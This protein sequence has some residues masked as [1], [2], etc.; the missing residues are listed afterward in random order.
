[1]MIPISFIA[2]VLFLLSHLQRCPALSNGLARTPPL[3]FNG[4][5][6][7]SCEGTET[8]YKAAAQ[9]LISLGL[10]E[11]GYNRLNIDCGWQAI[12]RTSDGTFAWNS[13]RYP[14]GIPFLSN[15]VHGLGLE[16]GL[17]SDAGFFACDD[18]GGTA[19]F[20][21]S[22]GFEESDAK[23]FASWGADYLKYDNCYAVSPT[24]FVNPNP[25]IDLKPHYTAMANALATVQRPI[26]FSI[27]EWG[28][29]DPAR[30]APSIGNSYRIANDIGPPASFDNLFRIINQVVPIT[31][32]AGPGAW[33]DLDLLEVGNPGLTVDE[34]KTHF[35]FWAAA[36]S[37]LLVST[38]LTNPSNTTL[39]ILKNMN[40]LAI[41]QDSLG[42][43][44]GFKRRYANDHDVWAGPLSDGSTV[45]I[46]INMQT[47]AR[48]ITFNLFDAGFISAKVTDLWTGASVGNSNTSYGF[49]FHR[50][51]TNL[52]AEILI[53]SRR[54]T[55]QIAAH[56]SLALKLTD[57]VRAQEP[58]FTFYP[59]SSPSNVLAGGAS[60]RVVNNTATVV[61]FIGKGGTLTFQNVSGG[62]TGGSKLIS[63][64]YINADIA[65]TNTACSNC[66][67]AFVSVNGATAVQAQFPLSGQSWDI[68]YSGYL[69]E[70]AGFR[71]GTI[72]S[73]EFSNPSAFAPDILRI[74]VAT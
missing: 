32:F 24:D 49:K 16:F 35:A 36:K 22:L 51:M 74:G 48:T 72:N 31:G 6:V 3:G 39:S 65:F 26:V 63:V 55:T 27:C 59:A 30:W 54:Y 42:I 73:V 71:P 9:S 44:I 28:V 69:L 1:M 33:N 29:Q 14:S 18:V 15:F 2:G 4:Y 64:D 19:H 10:L 66:R 37:P 60:T 68:L 43:S 17:Y 21:G 50:D 53:L 34:Q 25:P 58:S 45:V 7:F 41:N 56:G 23:T 38:N 61:D 5:N 8:A 70:V 67:N 12:N 20:I 13:T 47:N 46:V 57:G 11:A 52:F 40:L 62:T